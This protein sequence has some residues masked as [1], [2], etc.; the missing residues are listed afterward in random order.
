MS[1]GSQLKIDLA[2]RAARPAP[3]FALHQVVKLTDGKTARVVR[4]ARWRATAGYLYQVAPLVPRRDGAGT[5]GWSRHPRLVP[6]S[7]ILRALRPEELKALPR[8]L[9]ELR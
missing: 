8:Q 9:G 5:E 7:R 6:E 1:T 2:N 4:A 3:Q